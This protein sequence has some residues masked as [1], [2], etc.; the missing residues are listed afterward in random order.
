MADQRLQCLLEASKA[1]FTLRYDPLALRNR[2][3]YRC[4]A[5]CLNLL[6]DDVI[7][8]VESYLMENQEMPCDNKVSLFFKLKYG[9]LIL[10]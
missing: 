6:E 5:K 2:C 3:F 8:M 4:V 9:V 7:E 1:G 10:S